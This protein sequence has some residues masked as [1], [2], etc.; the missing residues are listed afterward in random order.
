MLEFFSTNSL[1]W[2]NLEYNRGA[3][4][5]LH[6]G[7]IHQGL[8]TQIDLTKH[9]LPGI[10]SNSL[11]NNYTLGKEGDII[12]AD[13]SED[14]RDIAKVVEFVNCDNKQVICGLHTI[15]A[16]D[17]LNATVTGFKGYA[18]SSKRFRN[19]IRNLA[20]GTKIY[21]INTRNFKECSIEMPSKAE[22]KKIT[23]VLSV[24]DKEIAFEKELLTLLQKQRTSLSK[25]LFI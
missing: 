22:Q 19:Q 1:S 8:P 21:S 16:R 23:S 25:K 14:T 10:K 9:K 7:L 6:Y 3:L 15:H 20:Q 13:A 2:E 17:K 4:F 11:P 12:F 5:N 18:F 24:I